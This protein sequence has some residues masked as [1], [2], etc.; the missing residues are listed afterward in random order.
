MLQP[1]IELE[2]CGKSRLRALNGRQHEDNEHCPNLHSGCA[3]HKK[4]TP[5]R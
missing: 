2:W 1:G 3:R 4:A 5:K